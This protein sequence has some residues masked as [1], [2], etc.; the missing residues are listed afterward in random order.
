M[1]GLFLGLRCSGLDLLIELL[2]KMSTR[3]IIDDQGQLACSDWRLFGG[4]TMQVLHRVNILMVI[5]LGSDKHTELVMTETSCVVARNLP[6]DLCLILAQQLAGQ[7]SCS[8]VSILG[9]G[10]LL[11]HLLTVVFIEASLT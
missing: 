5:N 7:V 6:S 4:I 8:P 11:R 10:R 1:R 3:I 2:S 9:D